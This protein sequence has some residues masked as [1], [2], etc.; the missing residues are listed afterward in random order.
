MSITRIEFLDLANECV[1]GDRNLQYGEPEDNFSDIAKLWSSY[2][3]IDIGPEDV[4]I[5]MCLFKIARLKSS[6]YESKD[7]WV[8]LIGYAACGGEIALRSTEDEK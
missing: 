8:D 6:C 1:C 2:L 7:S 3:D 5:M 4:A